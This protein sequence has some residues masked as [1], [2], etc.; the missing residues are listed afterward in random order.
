MRNIRNMGGEKEQRTRSQNT[1]GLPKRM[2]ET[3]YSPAGCCRRY[4]LNTLFVNMQIEFQLLRFVEFCTGRPLLHA[5]GLYMV[6][7]PFHEV[8][9][10]RYNTD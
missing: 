7:K 9:A 8:F 3:T 6:A 4:C 5:N 10:C 1:P 2:Q